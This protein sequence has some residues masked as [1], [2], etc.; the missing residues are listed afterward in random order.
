[1]FFS[2]S[3]LSAPENVPNVTLWPQEK[4]AN[5]FCNFAEGFGFKRIASRCKDTVMAG[6]KVLMA[7][8]AVCVAGLCLSGK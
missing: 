8:K 5:L 3:P 2:Y 1:M 6:E 7:Q 4:T